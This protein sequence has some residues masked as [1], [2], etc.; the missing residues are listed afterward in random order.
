MPRQTPAPLPP[1]DAVATF[2]HRALTG[3]EYSRLL[4]AINAFAEVSGLGSGDFVQA[5]RDLAAARRA[6]DPCPRCS[7]AARP[8]FTV[9]VAAQV[10][11]EQ[12]A[13]SYVCGMCSTTWSAEFHEPSEPPR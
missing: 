9:P 12:I 3:P 8:R 11:G 10:D 6:Y 4:L 13:C 1:P 2:D 5:V 7:V